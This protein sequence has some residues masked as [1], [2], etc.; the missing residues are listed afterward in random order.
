MKY[1]VRT[2]GE[3]T[4]DGSFSQIEYELLVDY[5]HNP[6]QSI[7]VQLKKI[8]KSNSIFME[9]DII[10]CKD[11]ENRINE[12]IKKYPNQIINFYFQ[13]LQYQVKG[14]RRGKDFLF[15]Q[16]VYYPRYIT[17]K[18][19]KEMEILLEEGFKFDQYDRLQAKAMERLGIDFISYRPML[20]QHK[21]GPSLLNNNWTNG[22]QTIYFVD[23]LENLGIDYDN[24]KVTLDYTYKKMKEI[25]PKYVEPKV[26]FK[27]RKR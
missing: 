14:L 5:E 9:D 24:A 7:I 10:L 22:A 19:A 21:K 6:V 15:N 20:V 8:S 26:V 23:D 11:F 16:C 18:I 3:R 12:V 1:F 2:T 27:N 13:P 17:S 4:L 25:N